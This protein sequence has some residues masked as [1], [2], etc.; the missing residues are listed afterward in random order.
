MDDFEKLKGLDFFGEAEELL[1]SL[2]S[3]L[4]EFEKDPEDA[5]ILNSIFRAAHTLKGSSGTVGHTAL[6][7]FTHHIEDLLDNMRSGKVTTTPDIID[8]L[9]ESV[10]LTRLITERLQNKEEVSEDFYAQMVEQLREYI[11][12][13]TEEVIYEKKRALDTEIDLALI[14]KLNKKTLKEAKAK[15]EEGRKFYQ[16]EIRLEADCIKNGLDPLPLIRYLRS[17]GDVIASTSTHNIPKLDKFDP[18]HL[19]LEEI[20]LLYTSNISRD[21]IEDIFEF[22]MEAGEICI[23]LFTAEELKTH[24][25]A[26]LDSFWHEEGSSDHDEIDEDTLRAALDIDGFLLDVNNSISRILKTIKSLEGPHDDSLNYAATEDF[27]QF[28]HRLVGDAGVLGLETIVR[29]ASPIELLLQEI[30]AGE[31]LFNEENILKIKKGAEDLAMAVLVIST[32]EEE[33]DLPVKTTTGTTEVPNSTDTV[34]SLKE[35]STKNKKTAKIKATKKTTQKSE[36]KI[37]EPKIEERE[38]DRRELSKDRRTSTDRRAGALASIR[39]DATRLDNLMDMVGE[40]V[41]TQA[42]VSQDKSLE[43]VTSP[44]LE[45]NLSQLVKIT[46]GIQDQVMSMRM[47]SLNATFRKMSRVARDVTKRSN[48]EITFKVHGEDTELDKTV[49]DEV[50]DPLTHLV[51]NAVDHGIETPEERITAGKPK[52]GTIELNAYHKGGSVVIDVRDDGKGLDKEKIREKAISKGLINKNDDLQDNDIYSLI[53]APGFSTAAEV[54]AIS[55]R[56]VG[57]DVVRKNV[58]KLRGRIEISSTEG[59]GT[60][61]SLMFPLTLASIEGMVVG[62]DEDRF[63]IPALSIEN[64]S[65]PKSTDVTIVAGRGELVE[66]RGQLFPLVRLNRLFK[67]FKDDKAP[68]D[69]ILVLVESDEK[70]CCLMVDNILGHQQVVIKSLDESFKE[71]KG[72]SGCSILGDGRV[73]LI[74]DVGGILNLTTA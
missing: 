68:E 38:D 7:G 67:N 41:I 60:V 28:F 72:V 11:P 19:Y 49:I 25:D 52:L 57:L 54:T 13:D 27:S 26:E 61:F 10:D 65:R 33:E 48:K 37:V 23:H 70:K 62:I 51:R 6:E 71:V 30:R 63:I 53:M 50:G 42:L 17:D 59:Q 34:K 69:S 35:S 47:L 22:A 31:V 15:A 56:G 29:C 8:T 45:K 1:D 73:G 3:L 14:K 4:L 58:E 18:L 44:R 55:G 43:E 20:K 24:Y 64:F 39:I 16:I 2:D 40:L 9:F 5:D 12:L 21:E 36:K 32:R 46:K 66:V 74:L